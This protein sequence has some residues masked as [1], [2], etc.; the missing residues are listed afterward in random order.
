MTTPRRKTKETGARFEQAVVELMRAAKGK[1]KPDKR[2]R[3]VSHPLARALKQCGTVHLY[4]DTA[5][6]MD[7]EIRGPIRELFA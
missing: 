2:I 1:R 5:D 3:L 4:T 7:E 6:R